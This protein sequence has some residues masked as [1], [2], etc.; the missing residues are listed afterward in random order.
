FSHHPGLADWPKETTYAELQPYYRRV[1]EFMNVQRLPEGQWTART[2]LMKEAAEKIGQAERF[3]VLE[4]AVSFDPELRFDPDHPPAD[5]PSKTFR[6]AQ[7]V[8]QGTCVHCGG[9]DIGCSYRAKNTLDLN[10]IPWAEKHGA[11][12]RPLHLVTNIEPVSGGYRVRY[13]RLE[14]GQRRAGSQTAS[15]VIVAA[16]SLGS[17]ELLLRCREDTRSLPRLSPCLGHQW[18]SNGDFLTPAVYPERFVEPTF[19][20]TISSALDFLDG[21]AGGRRFWIQDG[22]F[23]DLLALY[24]KRRAGQTIRGLRARLLLEAVHGLLQLEKPFRHIMPWFAQAVDAGNGILRLRRRWW[25]WGRRELDLEWDVTQS[26]PAF[27]AVLAMHQRLSEKTGGTPLVPPTWFLAHDLITPH[28]LGGCN[29][30]AT[31]A[32]GVVDHTG[33]VFGYANLYVADAAII[34][35]ALGVNPSRTIGA[36]AERIAKLILEKARP[37]IGVNP[38]GARQY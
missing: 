18:S 10:Y 37:Q 24:L 13:D 15:L 25:L 26:R 33:E 12:V 1:Q 4:L 17:T 3:K 27:D 14:G 21:S 22:G 32:D 8:E 31:P 16:G 6:N 7:G 11:E 5:L 28:P 35:R 2:R 20:L 23:P 34:P 29:M 30:G 36:L 38:E 9:C 19:G